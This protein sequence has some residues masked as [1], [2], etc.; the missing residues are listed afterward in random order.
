MLAICTMVMA[1]GMFTVF[2][3]AYG[4]GQARRTNSPA[5]SMFIV[6]LLGIVLMFMGVTKMAEIAG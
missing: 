2:A 1:I 5:G 4:L 6:I 3:G